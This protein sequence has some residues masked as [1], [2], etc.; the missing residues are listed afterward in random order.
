MRQSCPEEAIEVVWVADGPAKHAVN[1]LHCGEQKLIELGEGLR[2]LETPLPCQR[3]RLFIQNA[4]DCDRIQE[5]RKGT[6][7]LAGVLCLPQIAA[8]LRYRSDCQGAGFVQRG[9]PPRQKSLV[10]EFVLLQTVGIAVK[11][12]FPGGAAQMPDEAVVFQP[13]RG[14]GSDRGIAGF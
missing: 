14:V 5:L 12:L 10:N 2:L 3:S 4:A 13:I 9:K 1:L 8:K 11:G 7:L 6:D